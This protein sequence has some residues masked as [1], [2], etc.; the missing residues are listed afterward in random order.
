MT[1]HREHIDNKLKR[2][3]RLYSSTT[4]KSQ[5]ISSSKLVLSVNNKISSYQ[6][7]VEFDFNQ[8]S[9]DSDLSETADVILKVPVRVRCLKESNALD[10][11][12]QGPYMIEPW[13]T[14]IGL[15]NAAEKYKRPNRGTRRYKIDLIISKVWTLGIKQLIRIYLTASFARINR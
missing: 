14:T 2:S 5:S 12:P 4:G 9:S 3:E 1:C 15:P 8:E 10:S 13:Q 6:V 11:E 7:S